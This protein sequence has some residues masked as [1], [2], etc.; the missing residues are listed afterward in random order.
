MKPISLLIFCILSLSP[1]FQS[2]AQILNGNFADG[3][4]DW[5][6]V[7][8]ASNTYSPGYGLTSSILGLGGGPLANAPAFY[9]NAGGGSEVDLTQSFFLSGGHQYSFSASL[10]MVSDSNNSDGGTV[11]IYLNQ[12][13]ISSHAFGAVS[14]AP[15]TPVYVALNGI[16]TAPSSG[17]ETLK[18]AFTRGPGVG[19]VYDTPTDYIGDIQ[20]V[21]EPATLALAG[22]GGLSVL[23][24]R[25]RQNKIL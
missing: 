23:W 13:L 19:G 20:M 25:R 11:S 24:F 21:P 7:L 17:T 6:V 4:N 15:S 14:Y 2:T 8:P 16:Y 22:V 10:A 12:S 18:I 9:A 1:V 3:L 5:T